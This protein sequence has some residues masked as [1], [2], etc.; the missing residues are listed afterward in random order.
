MTESAGTGVREQR[1]T[2]AARICVANGM[3][4]N[5]RIFLEPDVNA[6]RGV[7]HP[8]DMMNSERRFF[9][10]RDEATGRVILLNKEVCVS[11]LIAQDPSEREPS[12]ED[13]LVAFEQR[14]VRMQMTAGEP[15]TGVVNLDSRIHAPR[16]SDVLN[17][18]RNHW[19][20]LATAEGEL[21]VNARF[22][23]SV[24]DLGDPAS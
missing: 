5:G 19:F 15:A 17:E 9:P 2:A 8:V 14:I 10:V 13:E 24:E 18:P 7:Q 11:M 21:L 22:V 1:I 16:V 12:G 23:I 4:M 3:A 20:M 6:A